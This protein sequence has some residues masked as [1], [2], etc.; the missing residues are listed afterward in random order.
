MKD[1][2]RFGR[3]LRGANRAIVAIEDTRVVGFARALFD[4]ASNGYI[5]TVAVAA[6][7]PDDELIE[8]PWTWA[9]DDAPF[10]AH[11]NPMRRPGDLI[12]MWQ[13]EFDAALALTGFFMVVCHPRFSGRPA[14]AIALDRL[15]AHAEAA[16][17]IW[18]ARCEEVAEY[19]RG[20]TTTPRYAAPEVAGERPFL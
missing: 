20:Q 17:S 7:R 10:Y 3:M 1:P 9:L 11:A 16:G 13:D 15:V 14:R 19:A 8:L 4:G 12:A 6:D 2:D 5:S 18:F